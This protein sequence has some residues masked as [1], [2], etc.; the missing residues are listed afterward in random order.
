MDYSFLVGVHHK[1]MGDLVNMAA[2]RPPPHAAPAAHDSGF[3]EEE[4]TPHP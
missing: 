1:E 3:E 4:Y 2:F